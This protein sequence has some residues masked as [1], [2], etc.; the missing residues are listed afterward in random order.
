M[1]IKP[2]PP[3]PSVPDWKHKLREEARKLLELQE[4][5]RITRAAQLADRAH[6]TVLHEIKN[7]SIGK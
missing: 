2:E 6:A 5:N 4:Q 1:S 3:D 7:T